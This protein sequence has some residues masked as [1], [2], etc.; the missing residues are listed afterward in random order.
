MYEPIKGA[1]APE[2]SNSGEL[3]SPRVGV[4]LEPGS[5]VVLGE[6][7]SAKKRWA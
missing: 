1:E 3:L 6:G 5:A 7:L 4:L 2:G